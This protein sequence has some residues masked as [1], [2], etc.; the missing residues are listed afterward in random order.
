MRNGPGVGRKYTLNSDY[1]NVKIKLSTVNQRPLKSLTVEVRFWYLK[2]PEKPTKVQI[3]NMFSQCKKNL[4]KQAREIYYGDKIISIEDVPN[5]LV[6]ETEKVFVIFE[7]TL[8][9]KTQFE[10]AAHLI[11]ELNPILDNLYREVFEGRNDLS[12]GKN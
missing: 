4:Q 8:F 6:S 11:Q 9:V 12:I 10:K 5:T 7:F 1:K 2:D 3:N